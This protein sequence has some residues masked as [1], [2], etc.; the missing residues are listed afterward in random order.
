M[1]PRMVRYGGE[2]LAFR[3]LGRTG[4][5]VT[6]V[7]VGSAPLGPQLFIFDEQWKLLL[8]YPPPDQ[9]PLAVVDL[10]LS[11]HGLTPLGGRRLA[12]VDALG[13]H[14]SVADAMLLMSVAVVFVVTARVYRK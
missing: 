1:L 14:L 6:P 12:D 11:G 2:G 4:L 9:P 8:A 7:C 10:Y 5:E 3:T 13:V